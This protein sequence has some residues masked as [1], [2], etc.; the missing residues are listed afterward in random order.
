VVELQFYLVDVE[1]FVEPVAV[2]PNIGAPN[3]DYLMMKH[4][5]Q[6]RDSF[7]AF[8]EEDFDVYDAIGGSEDEDSV[9]SNN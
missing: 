1:C 7:V 5:E 3:N 2:I 8:L 6:W 9:D 4:R